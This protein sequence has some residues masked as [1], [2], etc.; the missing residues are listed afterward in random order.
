MKWSLQRSITLMFGSALIVLV[1]IGLM[2]YRTTKQLV[3]SIE[4]VS[5]SH[6]II[7]DLKS[8]IAAITE[9]ESVTRG[10]VL[11]GD[12]D[13]FHRE[14]LLA[15]S[16][17]RLLGHLH[18][19]TSD[20]P[21]TQGRVHL[22]DSLAHLRFE[23]LA[24]R[25]REFH[26]TG[27][28]MAQSA[29]YALRGKTLMDSIY[30]VASSVEAEQ[31]HAL[32]VHTRETD[33]TVVQTVLIIVVGNFL[34]FT[35]LLFVLFLLN[36]EIN[37]RRRTEIALA[38]SEQKFRLLVESATDIFYR[39]DRQGRFAY[40]NPVSLKTTG[41]TEEEVIG[42]RYSAIIH[43][44]YRAE[45]E[46]FYRRQLIEKIPNTYKEF[47]VIKKDGS[48]LWVGQNVQMLTDQ[49][50]MIGFQALARDISD[51]KR[52]EEER[53]RYFNL[54]LDFLCVTGFDGYFRQINP[55]WEKAFGFS[56]AEFLAE[57][58]LHFV[59]PEDVPATAA[60]LERVS[61]GEN[62]RAFE[63]RFRHKNGS[64]LWT[65]WTATP[66]LDQQI[67][68]AV[69]R[70]TTERK[71]IEQA[72]KESIVLQNAILNGTNYSIIS[73]SP[74]G[75]IRSFN[76]AAELMLGYASEE[77]IGKTTP[78]IMHDP[79]E[80]RSR[81]ASLSTELGRPIEPGFE[82][83]VAKPRAGATEEREW[84]YIRKNGTSFPVLLSVT[85]LRD[86]RG[87]ITG[88][89][90]IA[91]DI[92]ERVQA[93]REL[94]R[95]KEAAESATRAKSQFL[96]MMS[97]EIRTPMNGVIGM[98]ELLSNTE[99]THE[100][101]EYVETIRKSG[102]SLLTIINDILDFSKFE[103]GSVEL[104]K[105]P[106]DLKA[107]IEE[108]FDVVAQKALGK[109]LDLLYLVDSQVPTFVIGDTTRL[110]QVLI[111]LVGNAI[112][113]TEKGEIVIHVQ[114]LGET[115]DRMRLQYSVKDTG[116]GIP[117]DRIERLFK[118][119]SQVD[120]S[121]TRRY[122]GTGL[123][124]AICSRLVE[125]MGGKI[126]VESTVGQGSVFH[127]T[128]SVGTT[129]ADISLPRMYVKGN[130]GDLAGK[131][132]LIVDDNATNIHILTLQC[133]Q[134]N[135][136]P[137]ATDSPTTALEWIRQGDPFDIAILDQNMSVM[138]GFALGESIRK[139]RT[140]ES[141]PLL[142]LSS[143]SNETAAKPPGSVFAGITSKPV[144]Q[145]ALFDLLVAT[146]SGK[147]VQTAKN[148][149]QSHST[150]P[151]DSPPLKIL[152]AEDN[153]VNQ[154][155]MRHVLKQLGYEA[156]IVPNGLDAIEAVER[157]R[158][159]VL[160]MDVQMP[161]MDGLEATRRIVARWGKQDRPVIIALTAD[162]MQGD[163]DKCIEAG[164]DDYLTKPIH[165][166]QLKDVLLRIATG[167]QTG[168][169]SASPETETQSNL[170]EEVME[171]LHQLGLESNL[172]FF[173]EL[174]ETYVPAMD[175]H[176][177]MLFQ[178]HA[179]GD[180]KKLLYAAHSLKGSSLNIGAKSF[181]AI[182]KTM[183]DLAATGS[184]ES[185]GLMSDQFKREFNALRTVVATIQQKLKKDL[186]KK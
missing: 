52:A 149:R 160:F 120:S 55:A 106:F 57:P 21:L 123:G 75:V 175:T 47:P 28:T 182:C 64:Y 11:S 154:Q 68:Y 34:G 119:F 18:L 112:K 43:P 31:R 110:R 39:T 104:E 74:E 161:Q 78:A 93:R 152:I 108:S 13:F 48:L 84:T 32:G 181:G 15:D 155:L 81:A 85:P 36:R 111:N 115:G 67:I 135:M 147:P 91:S 126:W 42:K 62:L 158:F 61:K 109:N 9:A 118:P 143:S 177:E 59:H 65:E 60:Q 128:I 63:T 101:H 159:D 79:E 77:V 117:P 142:L 98:T 129:S 146:L 133:Q 37:T 140:K 41:Y 132:I 25:I 131:R 150:P 168:A 176:A 16:L 99:L 2:S 22:L 56:H 71:R 130:T 141:L 127:F 29:R 145:S 134:W 88:F 125:A 7:L 5:T 40:V 6:T 33:K 178:A 51:R 10:Y 166:D 86:T 122:G 121:T 27:A 54:S 151:G 66:Y 164:M 1:V 186:A 26:S 179:N 45:A 83:F 8:I 80:V 139:L 4:D 82:V 116:I 76:A 3:E 100:Q 138:D 144:K 50:T 24:E 156:K 58:F 174:L 70:D 165:R 113:F 23:Q 114:S 185:I 46:Q 169:F 97:H 183:E 35:L 184:L 30:A 20:R 171:R 105:R 17:P 53:D 136:L 167:K 180:A 170:H 173:V 38:E 89:L 19:M 96:A 44:D 163:R 107:C 12:K 153:D 172:E 102:D 94:E 14:K 69:G 137:R 148:A 73:T 157:A 124:L 103:S 95:A 72:L 87:E 92:T 162:A 49:E 90:G